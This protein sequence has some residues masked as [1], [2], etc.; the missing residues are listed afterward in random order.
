MNKFI[1]CAALLSLSIAASAARPQA[2]LP[3][4]TFET[5]K[6]N[7]ITAVKDQFHSGTCWAFST[8]GFV[9]SEI[10]RINGIKDPQKYP[11]LSVF[12]TISNSY[13][14]KGLKYVRLDG[15]MA[16]GA[17]SQFGDVMHV[18]K[19]HGIVPMKEMTGMNYGTEKPE[20]S[21]LDAVLSAYLKAV[22]SNPNGKLSTAWKRG[23]S[24]ILD[25]YFGALPQKFVVD[26]KEY[27]PAT[28][29]DALKFNPDDYVNI[30]SFSHHP[31]YKSFIV[32]VPDN[33][34]WDSSY[35]IP[36]DELMNLIDS[37]VNGGYTI[38]WACDVSQYGF[39]RSGMAVMLDR[40]ASESEGSDQERWVGKD[41][42]DTAPE[43]EVIEQEPT[44]K[45][46]QADF[47][48]KTMT[49]DHGMQIFGIAKDQNGKKYYM[50][51][52]SWGETGK[53]KGIWY[54]TEAYVK[55]QTLS[56][57]IHKDALPKDLKTKLGLSR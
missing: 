24:G 28:Y 52:N 37:A 33:W 22:A 1:F 8:M 30:T 20:Q 10:I 7:P 42:E 16:Y 6:A 23:L 35:N 50:V 4:Y 12:Y 32:E 18:I 55:A 46:R 26:G 3:D 44:Q 39:T 31:F 11:D 29:R 25:A 49:D 34:R 15:N 9:E 21:E 36:V 17:G 13:F 57:L 54:A 47:D 41:K 38:A 2:K 27:T 45:S 40:S 53:Y 19:D 51:K 43:P 5:V 56:I 48:N 14:E